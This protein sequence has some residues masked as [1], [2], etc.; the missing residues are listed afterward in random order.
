MSKTRSFV[1]LLVASGPK[2]IEVA[3][4]VHNSGLVDARRNY[5]G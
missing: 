1:L 5:G 2:N 4:P 3:R